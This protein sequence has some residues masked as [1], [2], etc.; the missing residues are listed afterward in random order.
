MSRPAVFRAL[1]NSRRHSPEHLPIE[2]DER[3][4]NPDVFVFV[5][6]IAV[7]RSGEL[8]GG[9]V[10]MDQPRDFVRVADEIRGELRADDEVDRFAVALAQVDEA[11][12]RGMREDFALRIPFERDA[13]ELG[14]HI[15]ARRSCWCS[16]RTWYSAPPRT[17]GTWT[18]QTMTR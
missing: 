14:L 10:L 17:N 15:R 12:G 18:S 6:E 5:R 11:P 8:V 3:L 7:L 13:D 9:P 4:T 1:E 16:A 2:I